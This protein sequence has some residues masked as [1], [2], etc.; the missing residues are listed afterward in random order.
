MSLGPTGWE[1]IVDAL[2]VC[3]AGKLRE[4]VGE[5]GGRVDVVELAGLDEARNGS[6]VFSAERM[7]C[8]EGILSLEGNRSHAALDGIVVDLQPTVIEEADQSRP[9]VEGVADLLAKLC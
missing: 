4:D 5:I 8:E 9:V 1:Q 7:A 3:A 6:P 2:T